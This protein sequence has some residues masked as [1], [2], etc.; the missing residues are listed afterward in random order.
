MFDNTRTLSNISFQAIFNQL[1][2]EIGVSDA[3]VEEVYALDDASLRSFS[4]AHGLI[5]LFRWKPSPNDDDEEPTCPEN[6]WFAN[7][8]IDNAC[9]SL[10]LLNIV[11][12]SSATLSKELQDF[13]E[14]STDLTPPLKGLA[15]ANYEHV[16]N[17]H[18][19][20]ARKAEMVDCDIYLAEQMV[21]KGKRV[22]NGGDAEDDEVFHFIAYVH[23][24]DALY[25]LDGLRR[26]PVKL[27]KYPP[28]ETGGG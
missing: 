16:R 12:N 6:I 8:V 18:N 14:Y 25:E 13:K 1:L 22:N 27:C 21:K 9:A 5:F 26:Q 10:A 7:Q 3:A 19:S 11:L 15:V 23:V 20:F 17:I 4:P 2:R 24:G 28:V